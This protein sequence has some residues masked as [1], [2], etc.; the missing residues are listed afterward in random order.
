[1]REEGLA[2]MDNVGRCESRRHCCWCLAASLNTGLDCMSARNQRPILRV[3]R[4]PEI[5]RQVYLLA[6]REMDEGTMDRFVAR[7]NIAKFRKRLEVETDEPKRQTALCLLDKER[8]KL[9]TAENAP[10]KKR[11]ARQR[12][13]AIRANA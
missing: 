6:G 7:L 9:A 2:H 8:A 5:L 4:L 13:Y 3:A 1:M 11:R 12:A 10:Q